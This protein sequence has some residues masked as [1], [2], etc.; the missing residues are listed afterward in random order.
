[1]MMNKIIHIYGRDYNSYFPTIESDYYFYA[2]WASNVAG[3]VLSYS[4]QFKMELWRNEKEISK[5]VSR[6][7]KDVNCRLFPA[8]TYPILGVWSMGIIKALKSEIINNQIIIHLHAGYDIQTYIYTLLF[9]KTPKVIV[10]CGTYPPVFSFRKT[11]NIK[12][13]LLH[14]LFKIA[15]KWY[16]FHIISG[17]NDRLYMISQIGENKVSDFTGVGIDFSKVK[18]IEKSEARKILNIPL[19]TK[20]LIYVGK[21]Y[22]TKGVQNIIS[23]FTRLKEKFEV[24][25]ILIGATKEDPFYD[26]AKEAGATILPRLNRDTELPVY[27]SAADVYLMANFE[28]PNELDFC[29]IGIAPLECI[30]C[31]TP[32]VS[33]TLKHFPSD[34]LYHVGKSP[35]NLLE[36]ELNIN[37][38]LENPGLYTNC[39]EYAIKY[40]DAEIIAKQTIA[41]YCKLLKN[42]YHGTC[43]EDFWNRYS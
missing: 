10:N 42:H 19:E 21:L 37:E 9:R 11:K 1:M 32:V 25:L 20:V 14:L 3:N 33:P 28:D 39:R 12:F 22:K 6:I 29:G 38:V 5:P 17:I 16:D 15:L 2:G 23:V 41:V 34:D 30:G 13:L 4:K 43:S 40:F 8:K 7:V 36:F 18:P 35:K 31:N 27:Y 24:K 26:M